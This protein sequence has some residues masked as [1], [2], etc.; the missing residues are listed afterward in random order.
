MQGLPQIGDIL[1]ETYRIES[2]LGQGGFGAVYLARQIS[3]DRQ[4]A[5]KVLVAHAM[6]VDEMIERF[7]REVMAVRNL[8]HP[9]N[10]RV[11][12]FRADRE[13]GLLYCAMEF[14]KGD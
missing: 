9:N 3:M 2:L 11:Y 13:D 4:V 1:D 8:Q 7:R 14:I 12:D 10:I 6:N 5:I